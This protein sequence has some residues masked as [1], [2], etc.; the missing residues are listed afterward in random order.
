MPAKELE[1]FGIDK[2]GLKR[3]VG[4]AIESEIT[5][6]GFKRY[7]YYFRE[8]PG[9]GEDKLLAQ[10]KRMR[11][12]DHYSRAETLLLQGFSLHGVNYQRSFRNSQMFFIHNRTTFVDPVVYDRTGSDVGYMKLAAM[13]DSTL[14]N[15]GTS[16]LSIGF[17]RVDKDDFLVLPGCTIFRYNYISYR[18]EELDLAKRV[19]EVLTIIQQG[20][21]ITSYDSVAL[22]FM[23][24]LLSASPENAPDGV[25]SAL[26][27]L[28]SPSSLFLPSKERILGKELIPEL[29]M[30]C[31]KRETFHVMDIV[32][33][34]VH[35]VDLLRGDK[36]LDDR[37]TIS[38][39]T[40]KVIPLLKIM[41]FCLHELGEDNLTFPEAPD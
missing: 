23:I 8:Y 21:D 34:F 1:L 40:S 6:R 24:E 22:Q 10:G 11:L 37:K 28:N 3:L 5:R 36:R 35:T 38:F 9:Y 2:F 30:L 33:C 20:M 29:A 17:Y 41:A 13:I 25:Y 39:R 26:N 19:N 18:Y 7:Y 27:D 15:E 12:Q 14:F 16:S 32:T 31:A 4:W